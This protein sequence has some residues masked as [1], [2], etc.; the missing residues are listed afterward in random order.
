MTTETIEIRECTIEDIGLKITG[1][2]APPL[3]ESVNKYLS[4]FAAPKREGEGNILLGNHLCL[5]C[6]RHLTGA[7]GTFRWGIANGEGSCSNCGW[8]GSGSA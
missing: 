4:D 5:K 6:G 2:D 1:Q 3:I 7:M 8:P